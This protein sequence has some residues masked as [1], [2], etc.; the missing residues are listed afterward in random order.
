MEI[1]LTFLNGAHNGQT[2]EFR[3]PRRLVVGRGEKADLPILDAKISRR[4]AELV[5]MDDAVHV[6]DLGSAN[7]TF[8]NGQRITVEKLE[9]GDRVRFADTEAVVEVSLSEGTLR[10]P[11]TTPVAPS[12]TPFFGPLPEIPGYQLVSCLGEGTVGAVFKARAKDGS[13][14]AIKVGKVRAETT[15]EDRKRFVRE[16][17]VARSLVHPNVVQVLDQGEHRGSLYLVMELVTGE[18]LR[19]RLSRTGP[20]PVAFALQ[21]FQP[22]ASAL[23]QARRQGLVHRDV[24]PENIVLR[25]DGVPKLTDFGLAKSVFGSGTDLTRPGDTVGTLAYMAPEQ[26]E[27][28]GSADH[29]ADIYA[30]GASLFHV[31]AGR[32]P[33]KATSTVEYFQKIRHEKAP[34][35]DELRPDVPPVVRA[36][37]QRCLMKKPEDRYKSAGEVARIL[38][39]LVGKQSAEETVS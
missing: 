1:S 3:G 9:S 33:F 26:I 12:V 22:I 28:A 7:G 19:A 14:V 16:A 35:L 6:E 4:H 25:E 18:S 2:L 21:V 37:V 24:K 17:A 29:A 10:L 15:A 36:I 20:F 32:V 11:A 5:V 27:R 31:L 39:Q 38:E 34:A 23:E 13:L 30:L 8:V